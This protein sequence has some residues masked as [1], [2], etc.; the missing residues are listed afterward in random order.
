MPPRLLS[1]IQ[2]L[3]LLVPHLALDMRV[4]P[5]GVVFLN[6]FPGRR[7]FVLEYS[8]TRGFG[9]S[10]VD[11]STTPFDAG[12]EHIFDDAE[13]AAECLL[14]LVREAVTSAHSHAA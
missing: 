10:E 6:V 7:E 1:L 2:D 11:E 14:N 3:H 12:H 4:L 8:P 13:P 5:T 9:I